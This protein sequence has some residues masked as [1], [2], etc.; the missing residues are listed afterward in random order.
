MNL[1]S[2]AI[3]CVVLALGVVRPSAAPASQPGV[4]PLPGLSLRV[5]LHHGPEALEA[6]TIRGVG[7]ARTDTAVHEFR[8]SLEIVRH[9]GG[10]PVA[11][12]DGAEV[13]GR[14]PITVT[15]A[16]TAP[17]PLELNGSRW[18]GAFEILE[19]QQRLRVLNMVGLEDYVRGVV[20]NEMFAHPEA[21][22]VQAIVSR[23]LALYVT[24]VERRWR[25]LG[26]DLVSTGA[27]QVYGGVGTETI[28]SNL[29]VDETAGL[30]LTH[31]GRVIFAAYDSN[32][33]GH[34]EAVDVVWPGSVP[35][36]FSYLQAVPSPHDQAALQLPGYEWTWQWSRAL[37]WDGLRAAVARAGLRP[38]EVQEVRPRAGGAS[39]RL[40]L[41]EIAHSGGVLVLHGADRIRTIL[42]IPGARA[43]IRSSAAGMSIEGFGLGHGVGLSQH[44]AWGM[45]QEGRRHPEILRHYYRG[46]QLQRFD[47]GMIRP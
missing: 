34:T 39:Q 9:A 37:S 22:R 29:A 42:G 24:F 2:I 27:D 19:D 35:A 15:P 3:V 17:G 6:V 46:V 23:T 10:P 25:G 38:G 43:V 32:A 8:R 13:P 40:M 20:S 16:A 26:F 21:F 7:S 33:G 31:E 28:L 14:L 1:W 47:P 36:R 45:A 18:R 41:L 12:V 44:G 4:A 11:R 5:A 30:V